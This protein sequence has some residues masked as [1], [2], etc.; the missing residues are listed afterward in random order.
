MKLKRLAFA[1]LAVLAAGWFAIGVFQ[2]RGADAMSADLSP[3]FL[4][5]QPVM[6]PLDGA[7]HWLNTKPLTAQELRGKVVLVQF[8]T[9]SCINWLRT[10][11]HVQAWADKYRDH[12]LVVIGVHTPEFGFEKEIA[13][14]AKA[15]ADLGVTYAV[16]VD[17]GG[18]IWRAFRNNA[19][20]AQY[21][22][23][24]R[25]AVRHRH[26]GE[27]EFLQSETIIQQLLME[28]GAT[29][30]DP[31]PVQVDGRGALAQAD[32]NHLASPETY[33]GHTRASGFASPGGLAPDRHRDYRAPQQLRLNAWALKGQWVVGPEAA[34]SQAAKA[35]VRFRFRA[36]D[37][38]LVM[39][40][41]AH[42]RP[43]PF[44]VLIDG[45]PP[46]RAHGVDVDA[47]GRGTLVEHKLYQL[48]RQPAPIEEREFEIEF[49]ESGAEV[50]AFT[51][52]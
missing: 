11:P 7:V 47:E 49:P 3:A 2:A 20:P 42:A 13:A 39:G 51:F 23:D 29:A 1:L 34:K 4:Q 44:R 48:L 33:L 37:L 5:T 8:W 16:A 26:I 52:G 10:L 21:F 40:P 38:H 18:T 46:G 9:F 22:V 32:W 50:F 31:D 17:S 25:G 15:T 41:Q 6:P 14:V 19:W 28:A 30:F 36:R 12:G 24:A 35:S 43:V 45:Q 27:G